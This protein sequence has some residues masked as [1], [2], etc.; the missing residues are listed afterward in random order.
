MPSFSPEK[1]CKMTLLVTF[2]LFLLYA[3][4]AMNG[5]EGTSE[6]AFLIQAGVLAFLLLTNAIVLCASTR[7]SEQ[8]YSG[9]VYRQ[10]YNNDRRCLLM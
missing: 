6:S 4:A 7:A 3:E 1:F 8:P 10:Q 9:Q 5:L 2:L